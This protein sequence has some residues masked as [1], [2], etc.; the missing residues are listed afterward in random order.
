MQQ[1]I[2]EPK[3]PKEFQPAPTEPGIYW[4]RVITLDFIGREMLGLPRKLKV[5]SGIPNERGHKLLV[6]TGLDKPHHRS[7]N[8]YRW[9]PPTINELDRLKRDIILPK[10]RIV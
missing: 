10:P 9:G 5:V 2:W 4:G 6:E 8:C 1:G 3:D 7:L